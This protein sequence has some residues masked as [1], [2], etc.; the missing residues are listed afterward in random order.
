MEKMSRLLIF[1]AAI[2]LA[3]VCVANSKVLAQT[4]APDVT[5]D[6]C[7]CNETSE[8]C[9]P[10]KAGDFIGDQ[11]DATKFY[12]CGT[13]ECFETFHCPDHTIWSQ[14]NHTC[15][16]AERITVSQYSEKLTDNTTNVTDNT[17]NVT[18]YSLPSTDV[19]SSSQSQDTTTSGGHTTQPAHSTQSPAKETTT[20]PSHHSTDSPTHWCYCNK[21]LS[22]HC[23][24]CKPA[25]FI[26]DPTDATKFY[27]CG[28]SECFQTFYC[29]NHTIW[30]QKNHT[31]I[32]ADLSTPATT[33]ATSSTGHPSS[34]AV[35][36]TSLPHTDTTEKS[37]SVISTE[38]SPSITTARLTTAH[39]IST[40]DVHTETTDHKTTHTASTHHD[41]TTTAHGNHTDDPTQSTSS[42]GNHSTATPGNHTTPTPGNHTT[43]T[44]GNH[45]TPI[46]GNHTTATPGHETTNHKTTVTSS[47]APG[48]TEKSSFD[49]GSF[50]GG[51]AAGIAIAILLLALIYLF[52]RFRKPT[53][54]YEQL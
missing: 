36:H 4:G 34:T 50:G 54:D 28:A 40:T 32:H 41:V 5:A 29:Q 9:K 48:T 2:T 26:G 22:E 47:V 10:C 52:Y 43:P 18:D 38:H 11:T 33:E 31:C 30:D 16:H 1:V 20:G 45:T 21:T 12:K 7:Y 14:K 8:H 19:K 6:W 53:P 44:P 15:I 49:G 3:L 23:K 42:P 51:I 39:L 25:D 37:T 35:P 24:P 46:P 27:K 17:T 13:S